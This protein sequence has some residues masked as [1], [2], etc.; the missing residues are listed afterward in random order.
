MATRVL[1]LHPDGLVDG[2]HN[3]DACAAARQAAAVWRRRECRR[4]PSAPAAPGIS[5]AR[6]GKAPCAGCAPLPGGRRRPLA[7][8][9]RPIAALQQEMADP[10]VAA[11]FA[12]LTALTAAL[13]EKNTA[14]EAAMTQWE[15]SQQQLETLEAAQE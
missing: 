2:G 12:R 3:Y 5:S 9:S 4:K 7:S 10:A 6:S 8:W 15:E 1:E 14:L 13:E 11:D